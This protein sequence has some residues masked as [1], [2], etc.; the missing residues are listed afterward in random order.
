MSDKLA[1]CIK[2]VGGEE[3]CRL[4][5]VADVSCRSAEDV[6]DIALE[7]SAY[8]AVKIRMDKFPTVS[9]ALQMCEASREAGWAIVIGCNENGPET[10][11]T[12]I[13][14]LAVAVGAGQFSAG[15][16]AAGE[17]FCK[18][19][20]LLEI[21]REDPSIRFVGKKFRKP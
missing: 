4:Q 16:I 8:N 19:S 13:A 6:R 15:G 3:S 1:Y 2:G 18:Y 12:F 20:R 7:G 14:D 21:A 10:M 9:K 11:D 5:V 17:H